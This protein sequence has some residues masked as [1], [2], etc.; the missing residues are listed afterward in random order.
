[1]GLL[2]TA[3]YMDFGD[4]DW[5]QVVTNPPEFEAI[6]DGVSLEI[7]DTTHKLYKLKFKKGARV[8]SFRVVGKFRITWDDESLL[9]KS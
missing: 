1:M 3:H 2:Y 6:K 5:K 4:D 8:K 7:S 9:E